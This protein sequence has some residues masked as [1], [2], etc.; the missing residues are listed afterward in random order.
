MAQPAPQ[1]ALNSQFDEACHRG[2]PVDAGKPK[3]EEVQQA[4]AQ[5]QTRRTR[6]LLSSDDLRELGIRYSRAQLWKMCQTNAF[7]APIKISQQR[8]AWI[9]SEIEAWLEARKAE[10]AV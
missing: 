7:P 3:T 10:R 4:L 2:P 8:S 5:V 9:A 6:L 1:V